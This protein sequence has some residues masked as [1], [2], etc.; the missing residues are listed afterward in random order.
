[1]ALALFQHSNMPLIMEGLEGQTQT[2]SIH[3]DENVKCPAD[4]MC[5]QC[6]NLYVCNASVHSIKL[7]LLALTDAY[8]TQHCFP[9]LLSTG[10]IKS[11]FQKAGGDSMVAMSIF[12]IQSMQ[13]H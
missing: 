6:Y 3:T 8:N 1:M 13:S 7:N 9:N 10:F 11:R 12:N 5:L 2:E 4:K